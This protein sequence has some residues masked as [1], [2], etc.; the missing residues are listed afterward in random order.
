MIHRT[1]C[2]TCGGGKL[3]KALDLG[4][5]PNSNSLVKKQDLSKV[6]SWPLRYY[7][8][9]RCGLFQQLD[10]IE[11]RALF[12]NNYTYQTRINT[13]AIKH[14]GELASIISK[15][16]QQKD[17]AIVIGSNDGTEIDILKKAGF[18]K[19]FGVEPA[20]NIAKIANDSGIKTIN[21]FFTFNLSKKI[22]KEYGQADVI[23]ANNV[24]AH[25][26][27]PKNMLLGMKNLIKPDGQII[28][29]VQWFR[30]VFKKLSIETLYAEH[31][32]EW[33]VRAMKKLA[34]RCKMKLVN[35]EYL[36]DQQGGSIRFTLK[37]HG[38][39]T[40]KLEKYEKTSGI[41]DFDQIS[42]LQQRAETRKNKLVRLL[43]K[44]KNEKKNVVI[45]AVPA[46]VPTLLN[47]CKIDSRYIKCAYD[48]T[49][50]KVGKF[51]PQANIQ[52]KDEKLLNQK[53]PDVPDYII[54]GAWNYLDFAKKKLKWFTKRDGKL[55]N[56]LTGKVINP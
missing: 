55:I 7:W 22:V 12:R 17:L 19:V 46:K 36:N 20:K 39:E 8:C 4:A 48:S 14:F 15:R 10:L 47:F 29:E 26:P 35:A 33:T 25:I 32:Y 49:P 30:D 38:N 41:Y 1:K 53:M 16:S 52:I 18:K 11:D 51:I 6:K 3:Y 44:L 42:K 27:D 9:T 24:F 5:M 31:Y 2:I 23:M 28:I 45:W 21:N 34:Q 56:M 13:P 54:I 50:T 40:S 37:L 43:K